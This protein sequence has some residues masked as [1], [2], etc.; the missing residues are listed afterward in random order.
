MEMAKQVLS[1][2]VESLGGLKLSCRAREF[3]FLIDEPVSKGGTNE[4]MNPLEALLCSLGACKMM[5]GRFF[6]QTKQIK[7]KRMAVN[8]HGE[9]DSDRLSGKPG[10]KV[11]FSHIRTVYQVEADN[12]EEEIRAFIDFIEHHC[13]V[14]DTLVN[15]P[16]FETEVQI[17]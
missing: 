13:P 14:K 12:T 3:E 2:H 8:V 17:D 16:S 7:L 10:I 4:A 11:G 5:V 9:I 15:C 6:Y 1:A